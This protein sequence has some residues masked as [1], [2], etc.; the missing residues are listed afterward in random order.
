MSFSNNAAHGAQAALQAWLDS[1][2]QYRLTVT[3][4]V[5]LRS[6]ELRMTRALST[7]WRWF[8]LRVRRIMRAET[9]IPRSHK[10]ASMPFGKT[11]A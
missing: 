9:R 2:S 7:E 11:A 6:D 3:R 4:Q 8:R 5:T 10:R 1:E